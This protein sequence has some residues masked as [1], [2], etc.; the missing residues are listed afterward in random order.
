LLTAFA[1]A[2]R[3]FAQ[4]V[5]AAEVIA[6]IQAVPGV[7][8]VDLNTLTPDT[9]TAPAQQP[10][11]LLSTDPGGVGLGAELLTINPSGIKLKEMTT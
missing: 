9:G 5:T 7:I 10:P 3:S 1:F 6:V 11:T 4:P 8:A 2:A